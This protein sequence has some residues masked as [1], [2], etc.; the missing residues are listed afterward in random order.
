MKLV[1]YVLGRTTRL[2]ALAKDTRGRGFH[3]HAAAMAPARRDRA[4]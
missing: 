3:A 4:H 1:S 2:G